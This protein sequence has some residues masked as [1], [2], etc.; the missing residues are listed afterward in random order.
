MAA[1]LFPLSAKSGPWWQ[2]A[3]QEKRHNIYAATTKFLPLSLVMLYWCIHETKSAFSLSYIV[4]TVARRLFALYAPLC[5]CPCLNFD[6]Y[7][8]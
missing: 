1:C 3:Q 7:L 8:G 2:G 5:D 6:L 4:Q